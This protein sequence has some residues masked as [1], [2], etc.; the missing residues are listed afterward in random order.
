MDDELGD[1]V[2]SDL[3][4]ETLPGTTTTAVVRDAF[5]FRYG[6][7]AYAMAAGDVEGVVPWRA[8]VPLPRADPRVRG[9]IQDRGRIVVLLAHPT[10]EPR[11][12]EDAAVTRVVICPTA[13][14]YVGLPASTTLRVGQVRF[15]REPHALATVDCEDG[16]VTF[17][18]PAQYV[19]K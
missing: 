10:G 8:P 11:S 16:V 12:E 13:K 4:S 1:F 3:D 18:E 19:M 17:L 7:Q 2:D 15:A 5:L 14:G 6:A 9:V